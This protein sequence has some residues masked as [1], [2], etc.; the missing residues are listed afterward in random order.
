MKEV[1]IYTDGACSG[2][3]GPGGWGAVLIYNDEQNN[4][5]MKIS[6]GNPDTTNNR[7]EL[8]AAICALKELS[9]QCRVLL[10]SDSAYLVNAFNKGWIKN[11]KRNSWK[12]KDKANVLNRDLWEEL[13][14]LDEKHSIEWIK[15]KGHAGDHYNEMC[16]ELAKNALK[17]CV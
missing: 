13:C 2:N 14:L 7:M 9:F 8:S 16:D 15:V 5:T 11:W 6:G 1:T 17:T 12:K 10:H 3:P 4:K